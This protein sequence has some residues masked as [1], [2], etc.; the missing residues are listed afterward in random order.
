MEK[1]G[2]FWSLIHIISPTTLSLLQFA[3]PR[4]VLTAAHCIHDGS[5]YLESARR[6][7]VGVLQLKAKK[8]RGGRRRRGEV[9]TGKKKGDEQIMEEGEE[10]NSI[11][12]DVVRG[13]GGPKGRR[14]RGTQKAACLP[15]DTH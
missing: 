4:A 7:K 6:L 15:L 5:D 12:G 13:K 2:A 1:M 11:D 3:S 9:E 14:S 10:E 8:I